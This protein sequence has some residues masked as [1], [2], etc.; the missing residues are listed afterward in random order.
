MNINT[1]TL[2]MRCLTFHIH[3]I[4]TQQTLHA[5]IVRLEQNV[6]AYAEFT[7]TG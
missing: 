6:G 5:E 7:T 2:L 3:S 1:A 4:V